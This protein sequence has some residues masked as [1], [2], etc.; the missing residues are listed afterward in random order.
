MTAGPH[1]HRM[2]APGFV[3]GASIHANSLRC[4]GRIPVPEI[5]VRLTASPVPTSSRGFPRLFLCPKTRGSALS[6]PSRP[7]FEIRFPLARYRERG[8]SR[9]QASDR[10]PSRKRPPLSGSSLVKK[11][12]HEPH[13]LTRIWKPCSGKFCLLGRSVDR[14]AEC[15]WVPGLRSRQGTNA[16]YRAET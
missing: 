11:P 8:Q 7:K 5:G 10:C 12:V 13:G 2:E 3:A 15:G 4:A 16:R 6:R 9:A 1:D 14:G